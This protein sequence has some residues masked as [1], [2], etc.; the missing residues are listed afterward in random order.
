M[1]AIGP[2]FLLIGAPKTGSTSVARYLSEHPDIFIPEQKELFYFI[3]DS[4]LKV[5]KADPMY[6]ALMKHAVIQ[7][8][9]YYGIFD[10]S[11]KRMKGEA[12]VHYLYHHDEVIPRVK[13]ELGDIKII[14]LLRDPVKRAFSNYNYQQRGQ[15]CSFE[16]AL[17]LESKRKENGYNSFWFYKEVG[18]YSK[19]VRHY[20][21]EFSEVRVCLFDDLK[22]N[23]AKVM[24]D[25]YEFLEVDSSYLPDTTQVHNKT[26][27]PKNKL[28]HKII[29]AKH[30]LGINLH[31]PDN[32]RR[33]FYE[34]SDRKLK[35]QTE[36]KLRT[37]YKEDL[38]IV[39]NLIGRDLKKWYS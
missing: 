18:L 4:L 11:S 34:Q 6:D 7:S 10:R 38:Q 35:T 28:W 2:N 16:E 22:E 27:V 5:S 20:L 1:S 19:P 32:L 15:T 37:F 39:E 33:L 30:K 21:E 24:R 36:S 3:K 26:N 13:A 12:T 25:L 14:L 8:Y 23:P 29:H 31:L 9:Q 17:E